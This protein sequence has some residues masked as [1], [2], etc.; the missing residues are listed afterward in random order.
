M[1][2][3]IEEKEPE[4]EKPCY[5]SSARFDDSREDCEP[6]EVW[7]R[8]M[9]YM[10]PTSSFNKDQKNKYFENLCFTETKSKVKKEVATKTAK[11][12]TKSKKSKA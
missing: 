5:T 11:K 4:E 6:C 3:K 2:K 1:I 9:G 10:R 8:V 7:T 12:A